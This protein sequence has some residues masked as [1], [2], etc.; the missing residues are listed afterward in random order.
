MCLGSG[1]RD[2]RSEIRDPGKNYSGSRI[3]GSKR[4]RI[5][6]PNPQHCINTSVLTQLVHRHI[7]TR[8]AIHA[9]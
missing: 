3:Q 8:K 7:H 1:I 6:D 5:P 4:H 9:L 2:P